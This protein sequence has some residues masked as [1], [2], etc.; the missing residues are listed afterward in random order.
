MVSRITYV[1]ER[2]QRAE[3]CVAAIS[4]KVNY[5]WQVCSVAIDARGLYFVRF[6][7]DDRP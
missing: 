4:E 2:F 1:Q 7:I 5:G 3:D 6:R